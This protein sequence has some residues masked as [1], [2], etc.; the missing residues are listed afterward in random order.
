MRVSGIPS[1]LGTVAMLLGLGAC[2]GSHPSAS[3]RVPPVPHSSAAPGLSGQPTPAHPNHVRYR[4]SD[5]LRF[6]AD[7]AVAQAVIH[8]HGRNLTLAP[9]VSASGARFSG[10]GI[11]YWSHGRDASLRLDGQRHQCEATALS[12]G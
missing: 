11:E 6:Q 5:G 10:Q 8:V 12:H 4:C 1:R 3:G 2:S 7:V 9:A